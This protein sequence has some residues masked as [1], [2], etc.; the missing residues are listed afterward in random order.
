MIIRL[1]CVSSMGKV[2]TGQ[3]LFVPHGVDRISKHVARNTMHV[4]HY[5]NPGSKVG[6]KISCPG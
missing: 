4:K 6:Q 3:Y 5:S 1:P 2:L